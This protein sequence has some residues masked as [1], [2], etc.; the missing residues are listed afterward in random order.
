MELFKTAVI[1]AGGKSSRMGFDKQFL[2]IK[3]NRLMDMLINEIKKEFRDI[4]IVTNKPEEYE[5][6]Y[7]ECRIFSDEIKE[8]G[9]LSGIHIG[10]KKSESKY[11]YFIACD[12]PRINVEYIKYMKT[13]LIRTKA[14]ACV[15]EEEN[16]I[17]PF[18]AF[19]S[20]EIFCK[21]ERLIEE[22]KRS[23]RALINVVNTHFVKEN[24][25]RKYNKEFDMFFN[26]NTQDD[27]KKFREN[28]DR[29]VAK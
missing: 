9:P 29:D 3:D 5:G 11:A 8:K 23:I 27:V 1:L 15:T 28:I 13:K 17:Q 20:K 16:R 19:Y 14:D 18:N 10:L 24:E 6:V 4:I 7:S 26:L 12:M 2:K 25:V 21:I 22:D